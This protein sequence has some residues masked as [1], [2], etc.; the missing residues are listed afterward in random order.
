MNHINTGGEYL[1]NRVWT[2][3]VFKESY[4]RYQDLV[5]WGVEFNKDENGDFYRWRMDPQR[6]CETLEFAG[7]RRRKSQIL[8]KQV[9][10]SGVKIF[11]RIMTIDLIKQDGK[12]V[13]AV[14]IP[15][16][17]YD[18]YIFKAKATVISTGAAAF[19]PMGWPV[20]ELTGDGQAMAYRAGAE[21]IGNEF[22]DTHGCD[23]DSPYYMDINSR[24][25]YGNLTSIPWIIS[26]GGS[27]KEPKFYSQLRGTIINSEGNEVPWRSDCNA[28]WFEL[29]MEAHA[30]RAP[31]FRHGTSMIGSAAGGMAN[32]TSE[33]LWPVN[34]KCASSLPGL[35]AAGDSLGSMQVGAVYPTMGLALAGAAVTGARAGLGAAEY[36]LQ[37]KMPKLY[38]EETDRLEKSTKAPLERKGGFSPR[39]VTQLLQNLTR[40]YFVLFI[41]DEKRMRAA[42]TLV[43][44]IRDHL[45]PKLY[46][47]DHHELRLV[48]ETKNM[49]LNT[50]IKLRSSLFREESR[51]WF[52]REDYPRRDDPDWLAWIK[53]KDEKGEIKLWKEPIPKE[54][55]PDLSKPYDERYPGRFPGE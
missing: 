2:E 16:N 41:K 3:I 53:L 38:K 45:V 44:F 5:S 7:E 28:F 25:N 36:A 20:A 39:W 4:A 8:R 21:L 1:N 35:F 22:L 26:K 11:D 6:P 9:A 54:W 30:G 19:K 49:L 40:P 46:A 29:E 42:L 13:G 51:G 23:A 27:A 10:E 50:D 55:W 17:K 43:E 33:G 15:M 48:H 18:L 14:G 12:V 47:E 52:Y 32:H 37:V 24:D 31:V 34:T